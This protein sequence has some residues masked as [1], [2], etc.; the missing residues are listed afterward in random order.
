ML[1]RILYKEQISD[2]VEDKELQEFLKNE[3]ASNHR[4]ASSAAL[5]RH[6]NL[7]PAQAMVRYQCESNIPSPLEQRFPAGEELLEARDRAG[8]E[9]LQVCST[10]GLLQGRGGRRHHHQ[11]AAGF[12]CEAGL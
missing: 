1:P 11:G 9:V 12:C 7:F 2:E 3:D 10:G 8:E 5:F 4:L 6:L